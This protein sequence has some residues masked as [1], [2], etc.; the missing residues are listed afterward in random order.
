[1]KASAWLL[2]LGL[3][4]AACD[5]PAPPL[6][7]AQGRTLLLHGV[8]LSESAK[9][10][11]GRTSW[12]TFED[13]AR[14]RDWGLHAV[15]LLVFWDAL[16]PE[17]GVIDEAYIDRV[18]ERVGWARQLGLIVILDLHQDIY[19]TKY[20][21]DGAPDWACLDEGQPFEPVDPWWMRN[22]QPAVRTAWNNFWETDSLQEHYREAFARLAERF[23]GDTTVIGYDL[24]NEPFGYYNPA[25][26]EK[27]QL[28][29]FY[30]KLGQ[31]L[32][33]VDPDK[34]LFYEPLS[35]LNAGLPSQIGD[36]AGLPA[37]Y[38]PH[39]YQLEVHEGKPY[40]G[41]QNEMR[42][43]VGLRQR[44]AGKWQRPLL[45]GEIGVIA[46]V[47][48][49]EAYIRDL[50]NLLDERRF[51]WFYW[52]YDRGS[53]S[54]FNLLDPDGHEFPVL[55]VLVRV[56][57]LRTAGE[58]VRFRTDPA[59]GVF[60]LLFKQ[61]AEASGPSEIVVPHRRFPNGFT[62]E[63]SDPAGTWSSTYDPERQIL[64]LE[65]DPG[66]VSHTVRLVPSP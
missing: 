22:L 32:H 46:G 45:F 21:G 37:V 34:L 14:L 35:P 65:A 19:S 2:G 53:D 62:V 27:N 56:Y 6:T 66:S 29:P 5:K 31:R 7:D 1:M 52:N 30:A 38:Y 17:P 41:D 15:R 55:D 18:E 24:M 51:G 3:L 25:D 4:L 36:M 13:Y 60:E 40:S 33:A 12:H 16:E 50:T 59:T 58:L 49:A 43:A 26:F 63:S 48:G 10:A 39:F 44:E 47:Q 54:G 9:R 23:V 11:D 57:P 28:A 42:W 8:N 20:T 64:T 61:T